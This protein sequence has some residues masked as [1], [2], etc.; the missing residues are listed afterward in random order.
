MSNA[1]RS[2][3]TKIQRGSIGAAT[4]KT[5]SS[6]AAAGNVATLTTSSAHGFNTG[7]S[8]TITG[9]VPAAYNGTYTLTV[10]SATT[11]TY[12]TSSAP[13][14]AATTMGT[15][16]GTVTT[17]ADIEEV[18]DVKIGGISVSTIDVT[19]L[20][21]QAKEYVAGLIDNGSLDASM[22]FTKG[23]VQMLVNADLNNGV[24][25]P[26]RMVIGPT[27]QSPINIY[28]LAFPTKW[29]GPT[30]KVDGKMDLQVSWKIT[31]ALT[32]A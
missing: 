22:N 13:G 31:G 14:G 27:L 2:Q 6:I 12:V 32:W 19:H 17:Y 4:S 23:A 21:S 26:Y 18:S 11:L 15:Y 5:I 1:I 25:S 9:A 28:F 8:I 10:T 24:T 30:A 16:T 3:G 29:D 7:D 20:Q